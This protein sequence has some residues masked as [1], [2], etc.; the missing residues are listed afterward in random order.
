MVSFVPS[1][2]L[3]SIIKISCDKEK[4]ERKFDDSEKMSLF[5]CESNCGS[6]FPKCGNINCMYHRSMSL[7][8][9]KIRGYDET[10]ATEC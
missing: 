1:S 8:L 10:I 7:T 5:E 6:D 4:M 3:R 2:V 9:R